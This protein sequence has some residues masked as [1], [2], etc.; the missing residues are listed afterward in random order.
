LDT[1]LNLEA[2]ATDKYSGNYFFDQMQGMADATGIDF[3]V[4][5]NNYFQNSNFMILKILENQTYS[6][7][8]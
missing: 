5:R 1:A 6:F 7:A 8:W 2:F 4:K 3:E